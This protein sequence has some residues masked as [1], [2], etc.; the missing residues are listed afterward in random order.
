MI[1]DQAARIGLALRTFCRVE[2]STMHLMKVSAAALL[3]TALSACGGSAG[4]DAPTAPATT[5][6]EASA[7]EPASGQYFSCFFNDAADDKKIHYVNDAAPV[8]EGADEASLGEG[9]LAKVRAEHELSG[10]IGEPLCTLGDT[11]AAT[12]LRAAF[13]TGNSEKRG[14][15]TIRVAYP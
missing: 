11:E 7:T 12:N 8:P 9:F 15:T 6:V 4:T 14:L 2:G 1:G 5:S 13:Y 3:A 10:I